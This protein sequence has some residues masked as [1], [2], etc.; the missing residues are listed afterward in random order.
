MHTCLPLN[1]ELPNCKEGTLLITMLG[2]GLSGNEVHT[3]P[4]A[5]STGVHTSPQ[6]P[7]Q[8]PLTGLLP[9]PADPH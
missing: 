2:E 1:S 6:I 7:C 3:M 8:F 9:P 4:T 5:P